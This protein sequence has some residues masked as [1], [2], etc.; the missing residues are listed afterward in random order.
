LGKWNDILSRDL[1]VQ[2][3]ELQSATAA[4]AVPFGPTHFESGC[5]FKVRGVRVVRTVQRDIGVEVLGTEGNVIRLIGCSQGANVLLVL[6]NGFG[7][8]V[9][10]L[11]NFIAGLTFKEGQLRDVSYEPSANS[12]RWNEYSAR[13]KEL[14]SLHASIA[15]SVALGVF[16][17]DEQGGLALARRMQFAKG[18][19][20]SLALYAAYA[21]DGLQRRDLVDEMRGYMESDLGL[22]FF[23]IALLSTRPKIGRIL[24]PFPMLSQGWA[25]LSAYRAELPA[26]LRGIEQRRLPSPWTL[27]NAAGV[28]MLER[29]ILSGEIR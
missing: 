20:P 2:T 26:S 3:A 17:L 18:V 10:A 4:Q 27:F 14:R 24:P 15:A 22:T 7:V 5:G 11:H 29:A 12:P 21:Y 23:D 16:R 13:A 25:L 6:D 1:G 28:D 8:V 19:D 9:P